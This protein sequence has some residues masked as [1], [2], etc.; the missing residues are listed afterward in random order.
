MSESRK[1]R[2]FKQRELE[3]LEV[4]IALFSKQGLDKVTVADIAKA[5]DIGKG[6]IYKHFV[7]KDV[8]LARIA[9]DFSRT[10]LKSVYNIDTTKSCEEQM[11]K[12]F[13]ICFTAHVEF[14]LTSEIYYLYQ[15]PSILQRLPQAYQQEYLA[16]ENEFFTIF[17]KICEEGKKNSELP[18]LP[19]DEIILGAY[20]TF[21]GALDMIK[22]KQL[23][24]FIDAPQISQQS[25]IN[26]IINYTLTGIFG[27][28]F[29]NQVTTS[30]D[31]HE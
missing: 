20:A 4:A 23:H 28:R 9:N 18:D 22:N 3:I 17:N 14:P 16:I 13:E 25:F 12:M 6:T 26:F 1:E 5:T 19:A 21:I 11:H 27:R 10:L 7:S 2:E 30:G 8:I 31:T 29:D 15:Q 24:C